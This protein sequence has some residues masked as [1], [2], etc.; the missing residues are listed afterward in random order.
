M[1]IPVSLK[2]Y[3]AILE[4]GLKTGLPVISAD[5]CAKL[6][7]IVYASNSEMVTHCP[8]M[9][10]DCGYAQKRFHIEGS[11]V[12]DADFAEKLRGYVRDIE[13]EIEETKK[14][15]GCY[16]MPEWCNEFVRERY[17]IKKLF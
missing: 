2:I 9:V 17:G 16:K 6:L 13:R 7:A 14:E 12:V 3:A 1:K 5:T 8:K 15:T 10:L 11:E 4:S